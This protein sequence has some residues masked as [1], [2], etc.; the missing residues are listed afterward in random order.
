MEEKS[1]RDRL[2]QALSGE[3]IT[4]PVYAVYDWFVANR[5]IDWQSLLDLGLG[6]INHASLFEVEHPH[7]K[8]EKSI[9]EHNYRKRKDGNT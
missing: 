8:I 5:K 1:I 6:Q 2:N 9:S 3:K 4:K 7:L